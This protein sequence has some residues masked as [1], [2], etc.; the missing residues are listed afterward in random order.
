MTDIVVIETPARKHLWPPDSEVR[1]A[2]TEFA[3]GCARTEKTCPLC[4]LVKVTAH[5]PQGWPFRE[6]RVCGGKVWRGDATPPCV[7]AA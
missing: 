1:L 4:G 5:P 3:D 6:W 2:A 7:G